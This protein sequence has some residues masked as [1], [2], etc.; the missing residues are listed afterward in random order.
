MRS[1]CLTLCLST[2]LISSHFLSQSGQAAELLQAD[3]IRYL[4]TIRHS[5]NGNRSGA[6]AADG[7]IAVANTGDDRVEFFDKDG[8]FLRDLGGPRQGDFS[9]PWA[10]DFNSRGGVAVADTGNDKIKFFDANNRF[11]R[12]IGMSSA[13]FYVSYG[14]ADKLIVARSTKVLVLG[15]DGVVIQ[16]FGERG[17]DPGQFWNLRSAAIH[18]NGSYATVDHALD[19]IQWFTANWDFIEESAGRGAQLGGLNRP[20]GCDFNPDGVLAVV[21][22][23]GRV[24]F[25]D[26]DRDV[27]FSINGSGTPDGT[28]RGLRGVRFGPGG[29]RLLVAEHNQV[30][31]FEITGPDLA[32][33][34]SDSPDP[35]VAGDTLTYTLT[36]ANNGPGEARGVVV[37][38]ILPAGVSLISTS[39]AA[40]DPSGVPTATLGTIAAGASKQYTITVSVDAATLG[41]IRDTAV[42]SSDGIDP[43]PDNDGSFAETLVLGQDYGDAPDPAYPTLL[44]ND[45]ARH[46]ISSLFLGASIDSEADGQATATADGDDLTNLNDEDGVVFSAPLAAAKTSSVSVT[47]SAPGLLNSWIDFNQDGDWSDPGEQIF[48]DQPLT[49]GVNVLNFTTP[50]EALDG[51]SFARFRFDSAGGLGTT[52]R[53]A[54]GEVEDYQVTVER[55]LDLVVSSTSSINPVVAGSAPGNLTYVA[56]VSNLGPIAA[57]GVELRKVL[58]LPAGVT[59]D[60]VTPSPGTSFADPVWTVGGLAVDSS[61]T[62]TVV[63]SIEAAAVDGSSIECATQLTAVNEIDTNSGN[64]SATE[65]TGVVRRVDL[66]IVIAESR[67]PVLAGFELPG[68]LTHVVTLT[69][70]GPSLASG[71]ELDLLNFFPTAVTRDSVMASTGTS[72][73]SPIWQIGELAPRASAT[74][75]VTFSVPEQVV[76]GT[77]RISSVS[78]VSALNETEL[79]DDN[80]SAFEATSV[81]SPTS[82]EGISISGDPA[83]D[84]QSGLLTQ[85]IRVT[86]NNPS[87]VRGFRLLVDGLPADVTVHN[88]QGDS[89]GLSFLLYN[90]VLAAGASIELAVE[91][92][93]ASGGGGFMPTFSIELLDPAAA[94]AQP[95]G[96]EVDRIVCLEDGDILLEFTSEIGAFYTI[97]YSSDATSWFNVVPDIIAGGTRQQWID[98]G[99]PKTPSHPSDCRSRF[100]RVLTTP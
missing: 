11:V 51:V 67:D 71:V 82:M 46:V 99:P 90:Q 49:A 70:H 68:N 48:V 22:L 10:V 98:N 43:N 36:V 31:V 20:E 42:V 94:V 65:V 25:W 66:A 40:E 56:T 23:N 84:F 80:D 16:E 63:L 18:P 32:L 60:S 7:T 83:L 14:P 33:S 28:F 77:D 26:N 92:Y 34:M 100:Y 86:N 41:T 78:M 57:T 58:D 73:T 3:Q 62:L 53:A 97:Q 4:F 24:Q 55:Q 72:F 38:N 2:L 54:D 69:N 88:A 87:E 15:P 21:D 6:I 37:N 9:D 8:V 27:M 85:T 81:V 1:P 93:Q 79:N 50:A 95:A 44:V 35:V 52:G 89:G 47:A 61:A 59:I 74:L 13:P 76:G 30:R 5:F 12:E 39:G 64:D 17:T 96:V 75:G 45:G 29:N 19:R 91:Y